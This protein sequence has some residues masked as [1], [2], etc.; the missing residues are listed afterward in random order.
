MNRYVLDTSVAVAWYIN[1]SFSPAARRWQERLLQGGTSLLVPSLHYLEFANVLRTLVMR[2]ELNA[3][4][5]REIYE[6]HMDA[7][8]ETAEPEIRSVLDTALKYGAT[9]YDAAYISLAMT[10][11]AR[12]ITAEKTTTVWIAKLADRIEPVR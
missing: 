10:H 4:L 3:E 12:L 5:A 11:D 6:L 8:L 1:E 7:P 2:R 9:A